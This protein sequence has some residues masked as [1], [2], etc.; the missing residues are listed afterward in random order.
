MTVDYNPVTDTYFLIASTPLGPEDGGVELVGATG[1]PV[2]NGFWVTNGA[3]GCGRSHPFIRASTQAPN[4]VISTTNCFAHVDIQLVTGTPSGTAPPPPGLV[5]RPLV[6]VDTPGNSAV[7]ST[8]GFVIAGWAVDMGATSGTGVDNV[9][10]WAFPSTGGAAILAGVASYGVPRPDVAA[11]LGNNANFTTSG[12]GLTAVLPQGSYTLAVYAHST[13]DNS[14]NTPK[15]E[16]ITVQPPPS[17]PLMWVDLPTQNQT[18]SSAPG[19]ITVGGWAVDLDSTN[20]PGV[21]AVHVWAYPQGG[22]A[23]QFVGWSTTGGPRP[24]I[25]GWLG[26]QFLNSGFYVTG[27]LPTGNYTLVVF[28]HSAIT[29]TFNDVKTVS[30]TVQ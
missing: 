28:A 10:A 16:N 5:S 12:Y 11:A 19:G 6:D 29:G 24:D 13:V 22:A 2:D 7:V 9:I 30:I 15:L 3:G 14:W 8:S 1:V 21:D 4:W 18:L 20:G 23:P 26:Q 25:A 17:N 27:Q